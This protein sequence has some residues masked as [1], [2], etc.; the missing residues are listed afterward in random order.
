MWHVSECNINK[1]ASTFN[2]SVVLKTYCKSCLF[3]I[4][5]F[6]LLIFLRHYD[7]FGTQV[8]VPQ[9]FICILTVFT[10]T[11]LKGGGR[12]SSNANGL[13]SINIFSQLIGQY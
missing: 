11:V 13:S 1:G 8:H 5:I 2:V 6:F 9:Y 12:L 4:Y 7:H 10:V 3:D